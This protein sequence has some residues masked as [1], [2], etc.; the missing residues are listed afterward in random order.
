MRR[1][2]HDRGRLLVLILALVLPVWGAFAQ[3]QAV[4]VRL[5]YQSSVSSL[6]VQVLDS[7]REAV[8]FKREPDLSE[9]AVRTGIRLGTDGFVGV[10]LDK[11]TRK[12]YIDENQ[13]L[14]LTDD[15]EPRSYA[16]GRYPWVEV[17]DVEVELSHGTKPFPYLLSLSCYSGS[18][19]S[20]HVQSG[21]AGDIELD[22]QPYRVEVM[23]NLDGAVG[24]RDSFFWA[25]EE[26]VEA[27]RITPRPEPP[28]MLTAGGKHYAI[29]YTFN[30][31]QPPA[32]LM[33]LTLEAPPMGEL[34]CTGESIERIVFTG[35]SLLVLEAPEGP[36]SVPEGL[37]HMRHVLVGTAPDKPRY[38]HDNYSGGSAVSVVRDK[39]S[40]F[41]AGG[42]LTPTIEARRYGRRL[43]LSSSLVGAS[44]Q[45]YSKVDRS[46]EEPRPR[47]EVYRGD[48]KV[49]SDAFEYG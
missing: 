21:W 5:E 2:F 7:H 37:Y 8:S 31:E 15:G 14:D 23:D 13:N 26:H 20:M 6:W 33:T 25:G 35:S 22:G 32:L 45:T 12:L 46:Y 40:S 24:K 43:N 39:R 27:A 10:V 16:A 30:D 19:V 17:R 47:F 42:P 28:E 41:A 9:D 18:R 44:G 11:G 48:E 49:A 36:M 34:E 1:H 4:E 3:E 29:K 38:M